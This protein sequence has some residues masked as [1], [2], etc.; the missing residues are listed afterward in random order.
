MLK[1]IYMGTPD[2]AVPALEVLNKHHQVLAV[3]TAPDKPAGRGRKLR[4][5]AVK[6]KA[7][8]LNIPV[9]QP[10]KLKEESFVEQMKALQ[11][12]LMVVVAF[13][14]LPAIIWKIPKIGTFNLHA[15]LLP[16]YRGAAPINHAIMNG[17]KITGNTSFFIDD[18][19]DTGKILLQNQVGIDENETAGELHDKLMM[20][21]A[22]LVLETVN[23]LEKGEIEPKVQTENVELKAAPKIFKQDCQI[24]WDD[25]GQD[26]HNQI[27]G[28]SPYPAAWTK[29]EYDGKS[30]IMKLYESRFRIESH[31]NEIGSVVDFDQEKISV[32]V[33]DGLI[34]ILKL[35]PENKKPMLVKDFRNGY[36]IEHL[37]FI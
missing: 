7:V 9:F 19:I 27:R 10:E 4:S 37:K 35:Q 3:V 22:E 18:K 15:S 17:E 5:S 29:I 21:G 11:P 14:M 16:Q 2:F 24:H 6:Q 1:I 13:R 36:Q 20:N 31:Q 34:D 25:N 28:L 32:A 12:D 33:K 8:E 23:Q 30:G 26:I